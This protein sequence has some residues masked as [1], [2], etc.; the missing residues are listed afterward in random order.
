MAN[1]IIDISDPNNLMDELKKA[2]SSKYT[3][4]AAGYIAADKGKKPSEDGNAPDIADIARW[5]EFGTERIPPRSFLGTAQKQ[6]NE[7]IPTI[8]QAL[9]EDNVDIEQICKKIGI[10]AQAEIK[11]QITRGEFDDNAKITLDGGWMRTKT[12][13]PFYVVGK[14][15][16][17]TGSTQPLRDTGNLLQSVHWAISTTHGDKIME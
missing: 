16:H 10:V 2:L 12:G 7:R 9:M 8:V 5:N 4:A 1:D 3:G 13:K 6:I 11:D 17:G 14:K 15:N